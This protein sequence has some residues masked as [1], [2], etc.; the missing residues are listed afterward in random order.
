M[1]TNHRRKTPSVANKIVSKRRIPWYNAGLR[2]EA[3][4]D[5]RHADAK[6]IRE[7]LAGNDAALFGASR[8]GNR[9]NW[10]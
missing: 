4:K 7:V 3:R 1:K 8:C 6:G 2:H 5:R 9:W 10:D